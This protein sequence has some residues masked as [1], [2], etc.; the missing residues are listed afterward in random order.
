V[1]VI[2][3][4][5]AFQFRL[6]NLKIVG[7]MDRIDR[8]TDSWGS[9][10]V[11]IIDYKTGAI[12][13]QKFADES[14]Q[15]SIYAMGAAEMGFI[16]RELVLLNLQG[17]QEVVTTR[18]PAQ[19]DRTRRQIREAADGIAAQE[20][21]PKPGLHCRWCEYERLCPATEQSVLIPVKALVAGVKG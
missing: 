6:D 15:L 21:D 1:E 19:L 10:S 13:N 5:A 14:L 8:V 18:T 20:F 11:R 9:D 4:E 7:R 3:A 16:A 17:N 2:A 12:R